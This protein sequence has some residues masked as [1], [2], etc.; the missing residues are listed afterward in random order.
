[1]RTLLTVYGH[2]LGSVVWADEYL[3]TVPYIPICGWGGVII[4]PSVF[5]GISILAVDEALWSDNDIP[6][7][8]INL[9][10][11]ITPMLSSSYLQ[12]YSTIQYTMY[13][14]SE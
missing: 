11:S 13:V 9:L 7:F 12:I 3:Y 10:P 4:L 14:L 5:T 8:F 6:N 2:L 1:M